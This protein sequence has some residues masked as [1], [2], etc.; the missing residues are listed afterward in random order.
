MF[1]LVTAATAVEPSTSLFG[2]VDW[3]NPSWDL[4]IILFFVVAAFLYGLSLGR[5]RIIVIL[6]SIY[7][8]LAVVTNAPFLRDASFQ[9]NINNTISQLFVVKISMF[10]IVFVLLFFLLSRS[11][12]MKTIASA[13][14]AGSWW[15]VFLF[16]FLHVGLIISIVLSFLPPEAASNLA[17]LTRKIFTSDIGRFC[18]IVGPILAM[19]LV[20][21]NKDKKFKY[22]I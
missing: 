9:S 1:A 18:W 14:Q 17:P 8:G 19:I 3:S 11:A 7:M 5:D 15:H 20:R 13:D 12:L 4:F 16:S 2:Q 22:D 21:G 10:I 6:V